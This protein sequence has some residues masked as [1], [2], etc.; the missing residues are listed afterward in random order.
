MLLGK[1]RENPIRPLINLLEKLK[2]DIAKYGSM[3]QKE[4]DAAN[5][6]CL[7]D[8]ERLQREINDAEVRIKQLNN[9]YASELKEHLRLVDQIKELQKDK[10]EAL[11]VLEA[12]RAERFKQN[13]AFL[14]K[15][16]VD[17]MNENAIHLAVEALEKGIR[18]SFLQTSY[19]PILTKIA[20][21]TNMNDV[22]RDKLTAFLSEGSGE[23]Y[24]PAS[25]E[26]IGILKSLG[27]E[28]L[29]EIV[30]DK[31]AEAA[32]V[33]I[34]E[35]LEEAKNKEIEKYSYFIIIKQSRIDELWV[36]VGKV[37]KEI[38]DLKKLIKINKKALADSEERCSRMREYHEKSVEMRM[39][40]DLVITKVI[41]MLNSDESLEMFKKTLKPIEFEVKLPDETFL[42]V[43]SKRQGI[44]KRALAALQKAGKRDSRINLIAMVLK[45]KKK[46]EGK[47]TQS[48]MDLV[49]EQIKTMI[50]NLKKE[51]AADQKKYDDCVNNFA[52]QQGLLD[53][54]REE[55]TTLQA[56]IE[57]HE[58]AIRNLD[59]EIGDLQKGLKEAADLMLKEKE[60]REKANLEFQELRKGD[61][62]ALKMLKSAKITL[63]KFYKPEL[64]VPKIP[65]TAAIQLSAAQREDLF[66]PSFL[67]LHARRR[68][69][70]VQEEESAVDPNARKEIYDPSY[71]KQHSAN[72]E[73]LKYLGKF[74]SNLEKEM[75]EE[76]E[77]EAD[78]QSEF[79]TYMVNYEARVTADS[80]LIADLNSQ[81]VAKENAL[82][83]LE[84]DM[85]GKKR[86]ELEILEEIKDINHECNYFKDN[87]K[88]LTEARAGEIESLKN[89]QAVLY[90]AEIDPVPR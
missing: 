23:R 56:S 2:A 78:A 22:D 15:L 6:Q 5:C 66:G 21:N 25:G 76:Q 74:I 17:Q 16:K 52:R 57:E 1:A 31:K 53:D 37:K 87:F 88:Q 81:K 28:I 33:K 85:Q 73:I 89:A 12:A 77:A 43:A 54:L 84:D 63:E 39:Q 79:E 48:D 47:F 50:A 42:Q 24:E 11:K 20:E 80:D 13:E 38:S 18:S 69:E 26:I 34:F 4:F 41:Q 8:E 46:K 67:Q 10:D 27:D 82:E 65:G 64:H 59:T 32:L 36:V 51:E 30:A 7:K 71:D 62:A 70:P 14:A 72:D 29:A 90:G 60:A 35:E 3:S 61:A 40:E 58:E 86:T 49:I 19:G 45:G 75:T 68:D 44:Q 55:M 83:D 9:E